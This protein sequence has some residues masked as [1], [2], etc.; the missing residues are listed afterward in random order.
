VLGI[1]IAVINELGG[2]REREGKMNVEGVSEQ[3]S[4][5]ES[6]GGVR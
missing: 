6:K 5:Q 2:V 3:R 1:I 4:K